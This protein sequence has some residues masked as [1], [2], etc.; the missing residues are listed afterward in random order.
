MPSATVKERF[1]AL[2]EEAISRCRVL[3]EDTEEPGFT[4]RTF[5]SEP[6]HAVHA[7]LRSW[8]ESAGMIVSID[9]AGNLRGRYQ[10]STVG[11]KRLIIASHLD[12]VPRAGAFDGILGVLLGLALVEVRE[13]LL[14]RR[15]S[16]GVA[17]SEA[18]TAFGLN[19]SKISEATLTG[20]AGYLEF[21]IE[22]G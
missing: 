6:M 9:P 4:T 21:H 15:D 13:E 11:A 17:L 5:L 2:A 3:A 16:S 19:P 22:Q 20:A 18:I 8:M 10:A 12:T 14:S 7:R 1:R